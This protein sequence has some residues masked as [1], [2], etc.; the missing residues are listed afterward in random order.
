MTRK[1]A[2]GGRTSKVDEAVKAVFEAKASE[3]TPDHL[4]DLVDELE[5]PQ[6]KAKTG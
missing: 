4:L 2:K 3:P 6:E 1:S 5:A